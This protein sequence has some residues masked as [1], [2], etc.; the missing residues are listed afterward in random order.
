[1]FS[2][3]LFFSTTGDSLGLVF[4]VLIFVL[5]ALASMRM[6]RRNNDAAIR[7]GLDD[8]GDPVVVNE[9]AAAQYVAT[10][11]EDFVRLD[12]AG[13]VVETE[14]IPQVEPLEAMPEPES[15]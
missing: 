8:N 4:I 11:G 2:L 10:E 14:I 6:I 3:F 5:F 7:L 9:N 1:M 13:P 15:R 12:P